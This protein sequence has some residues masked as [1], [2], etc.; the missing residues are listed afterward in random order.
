MNLKEALARG[1]LKEF[2]KEHEI[3][4]AEKHPQGKERMDALMDAMIPKSVGGAAKPSV[5][6]K[7]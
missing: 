7:K 2:A 6:K 4:P 5:T 1:K 3:K